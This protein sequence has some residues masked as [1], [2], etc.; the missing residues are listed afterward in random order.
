[1]SDKIQVGIYRIESN[2]RLMDMQWEV[3]H[4]DYEQQELSVTQSGN[5]HLELYYK[6]QN[7]N[8]NWKSFFDPIVADGQA[9]IAP[10]VGFSESYIMLLYKDGERQNIYAVTGGNGHFVIQN[11]IDG[12]FGL[13]VFSR[14]INK[15]DKVIKSARE[16]SVLGGI[17]GATFYFRNT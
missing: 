6:K 3:N 17:L 16:K 12:Q 5:Y 9:I 2:H 11:Y 4:K 8:P 10:N 1:M 14:L 13:D 15:D 7:T